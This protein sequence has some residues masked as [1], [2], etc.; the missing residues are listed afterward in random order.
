MKARQLSKRRNE[1]RR[2]KMASIEEN[3][4]GQKRGLCAGVKNN[5]TTRIVARESCSA[6]RYGGPIHII[7]LSFIGDNVY[8]LAT[9]AGRIRDV[10][11]VRQRR[12]GISIRKNMAKSSSY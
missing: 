11:S 10:T 6:C 3:I 1:E 8:R 2:K 4:W 7:S 9:C 5:G 12:S